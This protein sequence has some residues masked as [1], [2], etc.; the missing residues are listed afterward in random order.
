MP[1]DRF[2]APEVRGK[3]WAIQNAEAV[4]ADIRAAAAE[5][6][7]RKGGLS[8][9]DVYELWTSA[10]YYCPPVEVI[11][12]RYEAARQ[13]GIASPASSAGRPS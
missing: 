11:E 2:E 9:T 5:I 3:T 13:L 1:G 8:A 10:G 7:E 4:P 12:E 6:I